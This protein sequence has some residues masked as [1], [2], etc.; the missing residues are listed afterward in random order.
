MVRRL[1]LIIAVLILPAV[2]MA[3]P[4]G[5]PAITIEESDQSPSLKGVTKI[6]VS[7]GDLSISGKTATLSTG[8]T[9][10][11]AVTLDLGDD[12]GNDSTD[13]GEIATTGDT[14]SIFTEASPDKL[15]I[16]VGNNW[17]TSDIAAEAQTGDSATAFFDAGT[18]ELARG[19]TGA[20]LSDPNADR[21]GFWDD[22]AG[23]FTWLTA[24]SGLTITDTTITAAGSADD[25]AYNSTTWNTNTD[26]ATKNALRDYFV[27]FDTDGDGDID[28]I[29]ASWTGVA[30]IATV[31]TITSGTWQGT[32]IDGA[33]L[34]ISGTTLETNIEDADLLLIYDDSATAVRS[35]SRGNFRAGIGAGSAIIFDI[36]DDGGND[37]T[38]VSE[39]ATSGDTN[40]IFTEP[41]AN[42]I[43]IDLSNNW[44]TADTAN[45]GDSA[46]SFFSSGTLENARLSAALQ[47]YAAITPSANMQ[48]FLANATFADMRADLDLEAGTD[49][50]SVSAADAA[51]E[52][53]DA[54]IAR[55]DTA[56]T[57]GADWEWQDGIA[58]SFGNDN[59][60]EVSY[61]ETTDDRL[62]YVHT[63]GAGADVY[64][65]LNDNA[66]DSTFTVT[67][68]DATYKAN[69]V[70]EGSLTVEQ[71]ISSGSGDSYIEFSNNASLAPSGYRIYA[72]GTE[73]KMSENGNEETIV[74]L[75]DGG[76]FTATSVNL[77]AVT[78]FEV[79][80]G[81][82]PATDAFGEVAADNNAWATSRGALEHFDGT[83]S[84]FVLAA[85]AS[86]TPTN[87]QVAKWNTGGT[88]T[89]ENDNDSGG[90]P[91]WQDV[92][93]P[94]SDATIDHD[95]GEETS[96]TYTGAF[97]TG[98]Q[99]LV[100]QLTG[101]PTGGVLMEARAADSDVVAFR[102]GDGTNYMQVSSTGTLTFAG[103]GGFTL[104]NDSVDS[105]HYVDGSIDTAHIAADQ[106]TSALIADD[107]IDSE[108]YAAG[109]IDTAHI[110]ADQITSALI[111]DDQ[112]DSEHYVA[113]SIDNEH[114][115]DNAVDT[116]EM[117][118][119]AVTDAEWGG[120]DW[121]TF[122]VL[123]PAD[124]DDP[125][126]GPIPIG[127]TITSLKC[128]T[129]GGGDVD[130]DLQE[131]D[132]NGANCAT[133]GI[134][135]AN[136]STTTV[137]DT[138]FTDAAIDADDYLKAVLTNSAGTVNQLACN[139]EFTR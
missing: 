116:A 74:T 19:G 17:P 36:G 77:A 95:A 103:T 67:N 126:I 64:W 29:D 105:E 26:A 91:E 51:F 48:T 98:S 42:K 68:S 81:A 128:V 14:N 43:L 24:G 46:T 1:L 111:A 59:D 45:A 106:I 134:A 66:A 78:N 114:L 79:P 133:G 53:V 132:A 10:G 39:I 89:W 120:S 138:S 99:F 122:T 15:L 4:P 41:S 35:I 3:A 97:S 57:V 137:T 28:S 55:M 38:D 49:F 117:A 119:D 86:D 109:S 85:L 125:L 76:T 52:A 65:D 72:E 124:G 129:L 136:V 60:W 84:T 69:M 21:I 58:Q 33:Y 92:T 25:T 90:T 61:D 131:C 12:G 102:A 40:S 50:Y 108:H 18:I 23:A 88:I 100:R 5:G 115:A 107:Q 139:F 22:S 113:A 56:D 82:D 96:F 62:E 135:V 31:G 127:I 9:P 7:N 13:L 130:V 70:V 110:A 34:D 123:S 2:V 83:A 87:G 47:L 6:V 32:A 94:T 118:D 80:N 101:N 71:V 37:S 16:A 30:G 44:P 104:A 27:L 112:I 8:G 63:A 121:E 73:M 20:S 54:E 75:E 93:D 11:Q